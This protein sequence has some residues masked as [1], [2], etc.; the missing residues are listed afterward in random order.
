[1][2]FKNKRFIFILVFLLL[3]SS[4][5]PVFADTMG[6]ESTTRAAKVIEL[7]GEVKVTKSGGEKAVKAFKGMGLTQGD[8][9]KTGNDGSVTLD[10]NEEKEVKISSNTYIVLSE[11]LE[12]IKSSKDKTT[13]NLLGGKIVVNIKKKLDTGSTFQVNTPTSVMGVRGTMF[14]VGYEEGT[15]DIAVL[16]GTVATVTYRPVEQPTGEVEREEIEILLTA[17]QQVTLDETI[18]APEEVEIEEV[19]A[20]TL[21]LLVLETIAENPDRVD[22]SLLENIEQVIEQRREEQQQEQERRQQEEQQIQQEIQQERESSVVYVTPTPS[23]T[24]TPEPTPTPTPTP[25]PTA[26]PTPTPTPRDEPEPEPS[27]SLSLSAD[28]AAV[29]AGSSTSVNFSVSPYTE[30]ISVS[31]SN[32][33]IATASYTSTT[34]DITGVEAGTAYIDV[35]ASLSGYQSMTKRITVTVNPA[36][37]SQ[38]ADVSVSTPFYIGD[39][40][41]NISGAMDASDN[42]INGAVNVTVTSNN[43]DEG[44]EG[45]VFNSTASFTSGSA[46]IPISLAEQGDQTLTIE[47]AGVADPSTVTVRKAQIY[48]G[49]SHTLAAGSDGT[50]WAWGNN[51]YG[52][53]GTNNDNE[54]NY[55]TRITVLNSIKKLA[56]G[57]N[58]TIALKNDGTVWAWGSNWTGQL[59]NNTDNNSMIPVQV[60]TSTSGTDFLTG[61]TDIAVSS[62]WGTAFAVKSDGTV[63]VWGNNGSG[64]LGKGSTSP[65]ASYIAVK[66]NIF[67]GITYS[68]KAIAAGYEHVLVLDNNNCVWAWGD[69]YYGQLGD[70]TTTSRSSP[71]I[72]KHTDLTQLAN[73]K[74][75]DAGENHSMALDNNGKVWSWGYNS[76]GQLGNNTTTNSTNPV[77]VRNIDNTAD[78]SNIT[79]IA[80][81]SSHTMALDSSGYI[82]AWGNNA[83]GQ[84]GDNTTT[85]RTLPVKV[86]GEGGTGYLAN[87]AIIDAGEDYCIAV[88]NSNVLYGWGNAGSG[89]LGNNDTAVNEYSTPIKSTSINRLL[90]IGI[91]VAN[92]T[93]SGTDTNIQYNLN[94]GADGSTGTWVTA[95]D[96]NTSGLTFNEGYVWIREAA[97]TSVSRKVAYLTRPSAPPF[98]LSNKDSSTA[99]LRYNNDGSWQDISLSI[100]YEYSTDSGANWALYTGTIDS[101]ANSNIIVRKAATASSLSSQP[102]ANLDAVLD[103]SGL[104][105]N[106]AGNTINNATNYMQ[107]NLNGGADGSTGTWEDYEGYVNFIEGN[108]WIRDISDL[109]NKAMLATVAAPA[110]A[111]IVSLSN[112]NSSTAVFM[113]STDGTGSQVTAAD[114]YQ[115]LDYAI[116]YWQDI[117]DATTVSSS[118]TRQIVVRTKATTTTLASLRTN[119]LDSE[120]DLTTVTMNVAAGQLNNTLTTMQYNLN[121]GADGS[122]GTWTTASAASTSNLTFVENGYVW[123]KETAHPI[124]KRLLG[125]VTKAGAPALSYDTGTRIISN[126]PSTCEYSLDEGIN[127]TSGTGANVTIPSGYCEVWARTKATESTLASNNSV[128]YF[129]ALINNLYATPGNNSANFMWKPA[130][131]AMTVALHMSTTSDT[132]GFTDTGLNI[133]PDAGTAVL[134]GLTN[135]TQYWFKLV[136]TGGVNEGESNVVTVTPT[137]VA[138]TAVSGG[139]YHTIGLKSDGTLWAWGSNNNGYTGLGIISGYT[140]T[141]AQIGTDIRWKQISAG[142]IFNAAIK[143]DGTLWTWGYNSYYDVLGYSAEYQTTPR[144]VGTDKDWKMVSA[145]DRHI[146]AI[147][148]DGSLWALGYNGA[149]QLGVGDKTNRSSFTRVGT[150][151]DWANIYAGSNHTLALKTDGTLW[152]WGN[153][154]YGQL[155]RDASG[156]YPS[157]G[158]VGTDTNWKT[159]AAGVWYTL[160][161]K[162][163]GTLWAWGNRGSGKLGDPAL[164]TDQFTP[165]RIGTD[166]NW[167]DVFTKGNASIALKTDDTLYAWGYNA[168]GQ[169]GD[170]TTTQVNAPV[171]ITGTWK[172]IS[173]GSNNTFAIKTDGSLWVWGYNETYNLGDGTNVN[174]LS[175][176]QISP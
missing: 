112:K 72:V 145:G 132:S 155:G 147:K 105:I 57:D 143:E 141:P 12:S 142:S 6:E 37:Q 73:I 166:T 162:T 151:T 91:N 93:L 25:R 152:S 63:W 23:I 71:V 10:L 52:E 170:G 130:V 47:I 92:G 113:K 27:I 14:Y 32:A 110:A 129:P 120:L 75:I 53:L 157:P 29:A 76:S 149:G 171:Q 35:T 148:D 135:G 126:V 153:N 172:Y 77:M 31:S 114:N 16:E 39:F 69:N 2:K 106:V 119:D 109:E 70:G 173:G 123:I 89:Q 98:I 20:E 165:Q 164:T 136:V 85:N 30:S 104:S 122:T 90:D 17:N 102:T 41:L 160:A 58:F 65:W 124:N 174:K 138:Y 128:M 48:A 18:S 86:K 118:G 60:M 44:A 100:N 167:D 175:P 125:Q 13:I 82:W 137:V 94:G 159:A 45:I 55:P 156:D 5:S 49:L 107:Y 99:T 34:I 84:L 87:V 51:G 66:S 127:W 9:I 79:D 97:V 101:L 150:D 11:L 1:M 176:I 68:A 168:Y 46:V 115:Y 78:L 22:E 64:L 117:T 21:D 83:R 81:G 139:D 50:G 26:E 116:G 80:A 161:V 134:G 121:G 154:T 38:S 144:Q 133:A 74:Q 36:S 96:G 54:Y 7:S 111:P 67:D 19:T 15:T 146:M 62:G 103:F 61:V 43:T 88:N 158:Q 95:I 56:A 33:S 131:E 40:R 28:T 108:V 42:N 3:F 169:V 8:S 4:F 163:D 59:G 24:P 140:T